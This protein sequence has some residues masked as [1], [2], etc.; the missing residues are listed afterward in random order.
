MYHEKINYATKKYP[1][2][3]EHLDVKY[4]PH[5]H[6]E[7]EI[8]YIVEGSL[9]VTIENNSFILTKG[10]ICIFTPG[11]IH[12]LYS[13][14]HNKVFVMKMFPIVDLSNI[15]L[16]NNVIRCNDSVYPTLL[17]NINRIISEHKKKDIGYELSVNICAEKIFLTILRDMKYTIMEKYTHVKLE[18]K[19]NFLSS[20]AELLEN[21]YTEEISLEYVAKQLNYTKSYFCHYFKHITGV[22]F[23]KYYTLFRLGKALQLMKENPKKTYIEIAG[24]SGFKNIRSFNLAFKEYLNCSP[25]EYMKKYYSA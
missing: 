14:L 24:N 22:T 2:I 18:N 3:I 19:S 1:F 5:F 13:D 8:I 16:H 20:V 25:R 21:E 17:E 9:G 11:L 7:P 12:N 23:W 10:D 6:E 15:Q 4:I